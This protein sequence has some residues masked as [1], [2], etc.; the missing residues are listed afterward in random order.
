MTYTYLNKI[1]YPKDLKKYKVKDL[2]KI[3]AELRQ[4]TIHAVS[5]TGGT[6]G[7]RTE[8][9]QGRP[10]RDCQAGCQAGHRR[11]GAALNP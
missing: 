10:V 3:A 6:R 8:H 7:F 2:I 4:K 5:K 9:L 1:N 11:T